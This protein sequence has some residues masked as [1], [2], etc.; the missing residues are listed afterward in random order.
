MRSKG[1][2]L[3]T[4][5][6]KMSQSIFRL[7]ASQCVLVQ[8]DRPKTPLRHLWTNCSHKLVWLLLRWLLMRGVTQEPLP[9][10]GF[11]KELYSFNT[12]LFTSNVRPQPSPHKPLFH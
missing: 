7:Y 6:Y 9:S 5:F 12:T 10:F 1:A 11:L 8:S 4:K 2:L 3:S